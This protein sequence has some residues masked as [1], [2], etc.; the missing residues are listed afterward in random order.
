MLRPTSSGLKPRRLTHTF[1]ASIGTPIWLK[2]AIRLGLLCLH[3]REDIQVLMGHADEKMTKHY[4]KGHDE[5]KIEC[6]E[7]RAELAFL[8]GSFA[9]VLQIADN[10]KGP[11]F[12]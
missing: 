5:K 11:T 12:R 2:R 7:V 9:K 8:G 1:P 10:K 6:M 4:Q 3:R